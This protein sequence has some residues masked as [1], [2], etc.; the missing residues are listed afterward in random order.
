[1]TAEAL[2][3]DEL[4]DVG[5]SLF[6]K[7]C[8]Q[9]KLVCNKSDRDR[10]GWDFRVE[11]P[12]E[13]SAGATLDQRAPRVCQVQVK[14]TAGES[15]TRVS[16]RLSAVE[17][18]A[19]DGAPAA[20][21]IFRM[22][23]DG[24]EL[25]GFV[26][27]LIDEQLARVLHRLRRVEADGRVDINHMTISFDYRKARRFKP[28]AEGLFEALS[29]IADPDVTGYAERKRDQLARLGY[30]DNGGIEAE[31]LIWIE[32]KDHLTRILSGLEP[33][34]PVQMKAYDRRFDI[35]VPY[36]GDLL[37]GVEEFNLELPPVGPC[38]IVVR[39]GPRQPAA[40]FQCE[41]YAPPPIEG[42]PLMVIKHPML[43]VLFR[44]DGLNL[45]TTG[46]F[47]EDGRALDD[48]ILLLRGL[49][50]LAS[51]TG[52]IELEFR[53]TRL[54]PVKLPQGGVDGPYIEQLPAM[55]EFAE[56]WKEALSLAGVAPGGKFTLDD[57]WQAEP[58]RMSLDM[59]FNPAPLARIEFD[60]IEG[61]EDAQQLEA[62]H[63]NTVR[64]AGA[65]LTFAV[66][67][68]LDRQGKDSASFASARYELVDIRPAVND[69]DAYGAEI[70][71]DNAFRIVIPPDNLIAGT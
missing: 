46:T 71:E 28:T 36:R 69:L 43:T 31:A 33:L 40:L 11:F 68:V 34:K 2:T 47:Q 55:L 45:E 37:D 4:G 30:D 66:R 26:F 3:P 19:K 29:E 51:G 62:L 23:P 39:N 1:M 22:R 5:E 10:T 60:V 48:W 67:V 14:S 65:A 17:R 59:L 52:T 38:D 61:A 32:S 41:A 16:A 57:I 8:G 24:T 50:Y 27:H 44:D 35:R 49:T 21:V 53:G 13:R 58:V 15:G 25:M 70:A 12:M 63:F 54:P 18:L 7:L 6:R 56:R 20:I 64:F 9:A 42:G